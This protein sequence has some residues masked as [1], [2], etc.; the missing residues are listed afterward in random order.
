MRFC[1]LFPVDSNRLCLVW[2]ELIISL[3]GLWKLH[4][5]LCVHIVGPITEFS[6]TE[7]SAKWV[8]RSLVRP[9]CLKLLRQVALMVVHVKMLKLHQH[10]CDRCKGKHDIDYSS[11]WWRMVNYGKMQRHNCAW[12][13]GEPGNINKLPRW[14]R[15]VTYVMWHWGH[16]AWFKGKY[17]RKRTKSCLTQAQREEMDERQDWTT[18]FLTK[19]DPPLI[20][21]SKAR[22]NW[23]RQEAILLKLH[24]FLQCTAPKTARV[25]DGISTAG[26]VLYVLKTECWH[27]HKATRA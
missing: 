1:V 6:L 22:T 12:C 21:T 27:V 8:I 23:N 15:F 26:P 24:Y 13:Q 18:A 11:H 16:N 14:P 17:T 3:N 19:Y 5:C 2:T 7:A 10:T 4:F 20:T 25:D 9:Q